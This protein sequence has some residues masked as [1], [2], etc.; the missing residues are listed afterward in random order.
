MK[1][2]ADQEVRLQFSERA[3]GDTEVVR[4]FLQIPTSVSLRIFAGIDIAALRICALSA[5]SSF[6]YSPSPIFP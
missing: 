1:P 2:G 4:I 6:A 3:A 5:K